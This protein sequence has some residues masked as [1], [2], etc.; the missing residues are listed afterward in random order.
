MNLT[1]SSGLIRLIKTTSKLRIFFRIR[2]LVPKYY[3]NMKQNLTKNL[4]IFNN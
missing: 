2:M 3:S 1:N 4:W